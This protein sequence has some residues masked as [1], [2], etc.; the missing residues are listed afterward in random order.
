M[1]EEKVQVEILYTNEINKS[2]WLYAV[3]LLDTEY[4]LDCF[5]TEKEAIDYCEKRGYIIKK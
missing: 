2:V 5:Y 1:D 3:Q 4:W